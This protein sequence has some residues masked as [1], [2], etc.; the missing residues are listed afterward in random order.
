VVLEALVNEFGQE[1]QAPGG[2]CVVRSWSRET[3]TGELMMRRIL[4]VLNAACV[5]IV[6]AGPPVTSQTDPGAVS[7]QYFESLQRQQWDSAA[8][9]VDPIAQQRFRNQA[10][11][12]LVFMAEHAA[13]LRRAMSSSGSGGLTAYG[14]DSLT[15]ARLAKYGAWRLPLYAGAPTIAE[16]SAMTP[17]ELLTRSFAAA[18]IV[19]MDGDCAPLNRPPKRRV[20]G[21]V[22]ENDSVAHVLY[23]H[24]RADSGFGE[25]RGA[26]SDP[27]RV[28]VV[29]VINRGGVWRVALWDGSPFP[30]ALTLMDK[31]MGLQPPTNSR[32][33]TKKERGGQ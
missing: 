2:R 23:R 25:M 6:T 18:G 27:W 28:D 31:R 16:L 30:S 10:L 3:I 7:Q 21:T 29:H 19:C 5:G 14:M 15:P 22:I 26:D 20:V 11:A 32:A 24:E 13:Q 9:L 33:R 8:A 1:T 4:F 12:M 17:L